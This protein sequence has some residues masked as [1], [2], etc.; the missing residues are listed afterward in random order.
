MVGI[1]LS[2][3]CKDVYGA[4]LASET[5]GFA[6]R[7]DSAEAAAD[8]PLWVAD[9]QDVGLPEAVDLLFID[10]S[11]LYH[12]T[13][14]ELAAW[15]PLMASRSAI[16]LHDTNLAP[17]CEYVRKVSRPLVHAVPRPGH[18]PLPWPNQV[19]RKCPVDQP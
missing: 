6:V 10:T 15:G 5:D 4:L 8:Y 12:D 19:C 17:S 11:H 13:V 16:I 3:G 2:E 7:A 14:R 18:R 9:R 1:D